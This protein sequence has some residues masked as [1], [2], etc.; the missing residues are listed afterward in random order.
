MWT[1]HG[2]FKMHAFC[3]RPRA[4]WSFECSLSALAVSI[5]T[6]RRNGAF[7]PCKCVNACHYTS[8]IVRTQHIR[9]WYLPMCFFVGVW[10]AIQVR[11]WMNFKQRSLC[12]YYNILSPQVCAMR[13]GNLRLNSRIP[14]NASVMFSYEKNGRL[15]STYQDR[16]QYGW[17]FSKND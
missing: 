1:E 2:W 8:A 6:P 12:S 4:V 5:F 16:D 17:L 11:M 14:Q 3:K 9:A 13:G 7:F 10:G 15:L